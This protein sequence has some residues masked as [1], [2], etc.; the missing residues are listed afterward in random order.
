MKDLVVG[1]GRKFVAILFILSVLISSA[2]FC[3][4]RVGSVGLEGRVTAS[5][6]TVAPVITEPKPNSHFK[7]R[8]LLSGTCEM[9]LLIQIFINEVFSGSVMQDDKFSIEVDYVWR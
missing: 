6:P 1:L 3:S 5:A 2:K 7:N 8:Q 9:I 4:V